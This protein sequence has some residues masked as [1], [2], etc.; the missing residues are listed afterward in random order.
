MKELKAPNFVSNKLATIFLA[1]SIEMGVAE[2]WQEK[3]VRLLEKS[4]WTIL[5]PRRSDWDSS[6]EQK[7]SNEK[8]NEQVNWELQGL[9]DSE[10]VLLYFDPNTKSPI[11]LLELGLIAGLNPK[12]LLVICPEGFYRKGNVDI[13]C[14]R[15][16]IKQYDSIESLIKCLP[17]I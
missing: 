3:V 1:G 9:E 12:K 8:F 4:R 13:V 2:N 6:W 11:T 15:Y 10:W 5:N 14:D 16:K 17:K 7:I